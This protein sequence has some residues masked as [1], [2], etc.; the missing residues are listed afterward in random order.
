VEEAV[1]EAKAK[2]RG[3]RDL[4]GKKE[5]LIHAY[6]ALLVSQTRLYT[7]GHSKYERPNNEIATR[8]KLLFLDDIVS[9]AINARR[10]I[11]MTGLKPFSNGCKI[12]RCAFDEREVP[13]L[14]ART[15]Q[16]IGFLSL[17]NSIVHSRYIDLLMSRFDFASTRPKTDKEAWLL[18]RLWEKIDNESRWPEYGIDP[19]IVI[20]P[21]QG[22]A[23]MA[24]LNDVIASS[25]TVSEKIIDVCGNSGIHLELDYRGL[26]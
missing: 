11:E 23:L 21:D 4:S 9:L 17:I 12:P 20:K 2:S 1:T 13:T 22:D 19:T 8:Q 15:P 10:L 18:Y 6:D 14:V 26:D 7:L 3:G 25:V 16:K 5:L 24:T